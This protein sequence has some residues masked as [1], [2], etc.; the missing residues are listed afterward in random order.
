MGSGD[1]RLS[2]A[3]RE[4]MST[5]MTVQAA[6]ARLQSDDGAGA[7][8]GDEHSVARRDAEAIIEGWPDAPKKAATKILD[9]Y[10][11]PNEA[12]P[13]KL[14]WYRSGPWAR[15][16]LTGNEVLHKFPMPHVDFFTQYVDYPVSAAKA[17][18]LLEFDGSVIL[19]RTAGQIGARCDDEAFNVLTLNLA[20]EI[21]EGRRAVEDAR[22]LYAE[23]AAAYVM[24]RDAPYAERLLF[25]PPEQETAD[26]DEVII[27]SG[28]AEQVKEKF[29]DLVGQGEPPQ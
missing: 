12:T 6:A 18:E 19:D 16:E 27:A 9:H 2:T 17:S 3:T 5:M 24:G 28:F 4:R 11:P 29:K 15:M 10:G 21:L 23:T 20:V 13:T 25:D 1:D 22:E 7:K 14:F 8:F 26:P